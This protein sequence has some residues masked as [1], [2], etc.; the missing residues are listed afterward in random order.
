MKLQRSVSR[1]AIECR[2]ECLGEFH[3]SC[4]KTELQ[5]EPHHVDKLV[6]TACLLHNILIDKEG[7]DEGVLQ[8]IDSTNIVENARSTVTGPRC[9]NRAGHAYYIRDQFKIF[10][11]TVGA[12]DFQDHQI[13]TYVHCHCFDD[14]LES[15]SHGYIQEMVV[16]AGMR[17][18]YWVSHGQIEEVFA[19]SKEDRKIC[20]IVFN[21]TVSLLDMKA[22]DP[23]NT[24]FG[25]FDM[26]SDVASSQQ[27]DT[28]HHVLTSSIETIGSQTLQSH[29]KCR[30]SYADAI[31]GTLS[32][33]MN[34]FQIIYS[35]SI[36]SDCG[37]IYEYQ[38][39]YCFV[40][41]R[42]DAD[43]CISSLEHTPV[44]FSPYVKI[45]EP[46]C[47]LPLMTSSIAQDILR[48]SLNDDVSLFKQYKAINLVH[49]SLLVKTNCCKIKPPT[50]LTPAITR[51]W[52]I[53]SGLFF[54]RLI[55]E[56]YTGITPEYY[57]L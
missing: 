49:V 41:L 48:M 54:T 31:P 42:I 19:H 21:A 1:S 4:L 40:Y 23:P 10:L 56:E 24:F 17:R 16:N 18:A 55:I 36:T 37:V 52:R 29:L 35:F 26:L 47:S 51:Q 53:T 11:N 32:H 3:F 44:N 28:I 14:I 20:R 15:Y 38:Q 27:L 13:D 5:V 6:L 7:L 30:Q 33:S 22:C 25:Q 9:Y 57:M 34:V 46:R 12:T 2:E 43:E 50:T 8:K 39:E 45:V